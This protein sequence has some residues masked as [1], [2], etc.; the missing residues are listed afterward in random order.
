MAILYVVD[1]RYNYIKLSRVSLQ[2]NYTN[3]QQKQHIS[4]LKSIYKILY[5]NYRN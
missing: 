3:Y 4:Q 5:A 1:G 2:Q